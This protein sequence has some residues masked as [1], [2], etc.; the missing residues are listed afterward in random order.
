M[1]VTLAAE[2]GLKGLYEMYR[3]A[4]EGHVNASRRE[5]WN[6]ARERKQFYE[7]LSVTSIRVI[8]V[9]AEIA[10]FIDFRPA[11]DGCRLHTMII[12]PDWQSRG[13]GAVVIERLRNEAKALDQPLMLSVLK[14]NPRAR[15]FYEREGFSVTSSTQDHDDLTWPGAD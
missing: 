11:A 10:G 6:D 2:H 15:S 1:N 13:V 9:D 3:V 4:M 8:R 12:V 14:T 7:Q 5:A